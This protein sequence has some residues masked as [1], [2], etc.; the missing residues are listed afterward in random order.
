MIN[1]FVFEDYVVFPSGHKN[2]H[3]EIERGLYVD[4]FAI[5]FYRPARVVHFA[6]KQE[7]LG[8]AIERNLVSV[9]RPC[10]I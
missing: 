4:S 5:D 8:L 10:D 1:R 6:Q 7:A 9:M 2:A 3:K